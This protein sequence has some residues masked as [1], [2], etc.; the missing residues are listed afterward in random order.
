MLVAFLVGFLLNCWVAFW[1]FFSH[2]DTPP[3][4]VRRTQPYQPYKGYPVVFQK[5]YLKTYLPTY[6]YIHKGELESLFN[7]VYFTN[8]KLREVSEVSNWNHQ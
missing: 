4:G 7:A 2:I 5:G 3:L 8:V 6:L 1:R